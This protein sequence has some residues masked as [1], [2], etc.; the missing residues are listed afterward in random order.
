MSRWSRGSGA[1]P[2]SGRLLVGH[3]AVPNLRRSGVDLAGRGVLSDPAH[4]RAVG[5]VAVLVD[6]L[7]REH[8][9]RVHAVAVD[10]RH[11]VGG[12]AHDRSR[13]LRQVGRVAL[14]ELHRERTV[15][16]LAP[17]DVGR[18]DLTLAVELRGDDHCRLVADR[19]R[20]VLD[21]DIREPRRL[22]LR[23]DA[24]LEHVHDL[25][26][27]QA[28]HLSGAVLDGE[29]RRVLHA[30]VA[31]VTLEVL[32]DDHERAI[33]SPLV[34]GEHA[35]RGRAAEEQQRVRARA[36]HLAVRED[37]VAEAV[38]RLAHRTALGIEASVEQ[39][40][41][42]LPSERRDLVG[43]VVAFQHC[44]VASV[45]AVELVLR[46]LDQDQVRALAVLADAEARDLLDRQQAEEQGELQ[47]DADGLGRPGDRHGGG[48]LELLRTNV[49]AGD[50]PGQ[51]GQVHGFPLI[52]PQGI[53]ASPDNAPGSAVSLAIRPAGCQGFSSNM[54]DVPKRTG[55]S[56]PEPKKRVKCE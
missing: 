15:V 33:G 11:L 37:R 32:V 25:V 23:H 48:V 1:A 54:P 4:G 40:D 5:R 9:G 38:E 12:Q 45:L 17:A 21:V 52:A 51:L 56:V 6:R 24:V 26:H 20:D 43:V 3:G 18:H 13:A 19:G 49:K 55:R 34:G 14:D 36:A 27:V 2:C 10:R 35:I 8:L 28:G 50:L 47:A 7:D 30:G 44:E 31:H 41:V 53:V 22:P 16:V 42:D 46:V 29:D 39:A